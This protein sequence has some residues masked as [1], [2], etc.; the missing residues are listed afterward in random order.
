MKQFLDFLGTDHIST[1]FWL[2]CYCYPERFRPITLDSLRPHVCLTL[3]EKNVHY[4]DILDSI[5]YL[6]DKK[7]VRVERPVGE[8]V[9]FS[10]TQ[11]GAYE[12]ESF[13][14]KFHDI[15]S[16]DNDDN[17]EWITKI[18]ESGIYPLDDMEKI[19]DVLNFLIDGIDNIDGNE[20]T[21]FFDRICEIAK[22]NAVPTLKFLGKTLA[23]KGIE[24]LL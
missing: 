3:R 19:E 15:F 16:E 17:D 4:D 7:F 20:P 9:G 22:T 1:K 24:E 23:I 5:N 18:E 12:L 14:L 13:L 2:L 8:I 11:K 10:I 21:N 6:E